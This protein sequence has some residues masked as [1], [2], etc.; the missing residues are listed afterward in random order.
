MARDFVAYRVVV[1]GGTGALGS[2]IV[3]QL[4]ARGAEVFVP[5]FD[6]AEI[7]RFPFVEHPKVHLTPGVDLARDAHARCF[8]DAIPGTLW[9]SIQVVGGF[10]MAPLAETSG[11]ELERLLRLNAVTCFNACREAA[12][13]MGERG[14]RLVNVAARPA[15]I[16]VA[17]MAAYAASKAAVVS[18]TRCL[19]EEL[20]PQK[21]WVNAVAPSI[22]DTAAN[23]QA[24]PDADFHLWPKTDDVAASALALASPDNR[25]ARGAVTP[26]YGRS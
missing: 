17:G 11:E 2:A 24:M 19:A 7:G 14:G 26:V 6:E 10:A 25:C 16:P 15:L 12:A 18:L 9:A 21:I 8:Y 4:L 1:T 20:A 5:C 3:G 13:R 23:R 22:M